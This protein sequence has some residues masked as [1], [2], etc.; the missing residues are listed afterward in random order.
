MR[1]V[2]L[3]LVVGACY[4]PT[5]APGAPCGAG[6]ACPSGQSCVAG[7]C[8][9]SGSGSANGDVFVVD[10]GVD[11][12]PLC[13][14]WTA[15]HF[16]PCALPAPLGNLN[17]TQV[18]SGFTWD[19]DTGVLKGKMNQTIAVTTMVLSQSGGPDVLLASVDN[20]IV[21]AA[22]N[23]DVIG[24]RP[25][26]I[27]VNGTAQIDGDITVNASFTSPGPGGAVTVT[28][29]C[30]AGQTGNAG[31]AATPSTGGGGGGFQGNG[32][33]G[34]SAGGGA[35]VGFAT[36]PTLIRGGCAG[37]IGGAGTLAA[38]APRGTGGGAIEIGARV[39]I[40]VGTFGSIHAGGGGGGY[41]RSFFGGGGGG[42]SG[43][44][45]GLDAPMIGVAGTLAANGGGG[46]GGASD[47][48][49]GA[50]GN[51]GAVSANA[52]SGGA[53]ATTGTVG[54]CGK[55]G[56]GSFGGT[57]SAEDGVSSGCGDSGAGGGAGYILF[58]SP[59]PNVT[60]TVSP[61]ALSGP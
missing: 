2:A 24:A 44:Y 10:E 41:G 33:R 6:D 49:T 55:G 46:G 14:T 36:P 61:P 19:T 50:N 38:T 25:L 47:S 26:L 27:A 39:S 53:G 17:L 60:G 32:G 3:A 42:G 18:Q 22:A 5:A 35:G 29:E 8:T 51:N 57:L 23:L 56:N 9:G 21:D 20:L 11:T 54:A 15:E 37:G 43:G 16:A 34:G 1:A 12:A 4:S 7:F 52:A 31:T 28:T 40:A 59:A 30:P 45:I 58:W 48:A 13:T